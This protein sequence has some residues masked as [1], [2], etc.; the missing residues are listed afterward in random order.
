LE[1]ITKAD[2]P[3]PEDP[4]FTGFTLDDFFDEN[5]IDFVNARK[6]LTEWIKLN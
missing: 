5:K 1:G 4:N 6:I 2:C 3:Q